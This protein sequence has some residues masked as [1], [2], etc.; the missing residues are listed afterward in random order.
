MLIIARIVM[1]LVIAYTSSIYWI[2]RGKMKLGRA[3]TSPPSFTKDALI[4]VGAHG[5][6]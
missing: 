1:R 3:V 5:V 4:K 6:S 2:F